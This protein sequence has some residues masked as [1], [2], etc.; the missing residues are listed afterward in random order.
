MTNIYALVDPRTQECR[1]VGKANNIHTRLRKNNT[2]AH[3][4][5]A[6]HKN[7]WLKNLHSDGLAP[8]VVVLEV[9][10]KAC[11]VEAERFW[12]QYMRFLGCRLTNST[13]GGDGG[14][15]LAHTEEA[16]QK[17][18]A[19]ASR[20]TGAA[21]PNY[22]KKHSEHTKD[23]IRKK[24][25]G[26]KCSPERRAQ[27]SAILAEIN[28]RPEVIAKRKAYVPSEETRRKLSE[29]SKGRI[30]SAETRAKLSLAH[31]GKV[32]TEE[33]C[34]NISLSKTGTPCPEVTKQ[35]VS[36]ALKGKPKPLETVLK[37]MEIN[38][39]KALAARGDK[40]QSRH[41]KK[42]WTRTDKRIE[43][44]TAALREKKKMQDVICELFQK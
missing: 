40:P 5:R 13:D 29:S 1:Y 20:R 7:S 9:V 26:R 10:P 39:A 33:H 38:R 28:T 24:A 32:R 4:L 12:V 41:S 43:E 19:S 27:L 37:L 16:K 30:K 42:R 18:S 35:A 17:L 14:L 22:G 25:A 8:D 21:N 36:K 44:L 3:K 15:G 2:S 34:R 6:T 11:W 31:K 23:L